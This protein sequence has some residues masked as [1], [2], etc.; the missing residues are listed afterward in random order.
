M[1][2]TGRPPATVGRSRSVVGLPSFR[3]LPARVDTCPSAALLTHSGRPS[4]LR[5]G[6]EAALQ[7]EVT[8]GGGGQLAAAA[9][10][11]AL[12]AEGGSWP[13]PLLRRPAPSYLI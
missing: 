3:Q 13:A 10:V 4:R 7:A 1:A 6:G 9:A 8:P 11:A 2:E 5:V 12:P